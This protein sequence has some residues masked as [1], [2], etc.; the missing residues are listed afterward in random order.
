MDIEPRKATAPYSLNSKK[1]ADATK[2]WLEKRGVKIEEIAELGM[3]LQKKYY[4]NLTMEER[5]HN[6]EQ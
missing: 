4:P 2:M 3:L 1:V 6:V 5:I